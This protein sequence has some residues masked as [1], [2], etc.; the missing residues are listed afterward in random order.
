MKNEFNELRNY[1]KEVKRKK[2]N[3]GH[4]PYILYNNSKKAISKIEAIKSKLNNTEEIEFCDYIIKELQKT[5]TLLE[6]YSL[7]DK[8]DTVIGDDML[9]NKV[10]D[11]VLINLRR[12]LNYFDELEED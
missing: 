1:F 4:D 2:W 6:L 9:F 7:S 8:R 12:F 11:N 3:N 10:R 5:S